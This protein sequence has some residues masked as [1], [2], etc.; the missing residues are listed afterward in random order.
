MRMGAMSTVQSWWAVAGIISVAFVTPGPNNIA[1]LAAASRGGFS[2]AAA[3]AGGVIAGTIA[4][5]VV[6]WA[7]AGLL[8][9]GIPAAQPVLAFA[10]GFYFAWLG[11]QL[12]RSNEVTE[13]GSAGSL[14]FAAMFILQFVNPKAWLLVLAVTAASHGGIVNLA[15]L[16]SIVFIISLVCLSLWAAAGRIVNSLFRGRAARRWVDRILGASLIGL[17]GIS[18]AQGLAG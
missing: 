1:V 15:V 10:G 16:A 8:F 7:G 12:F 14:S 9:E 18:L 5:V 17:A 13:G 6:S 3:T 11:V 2:G 4:L